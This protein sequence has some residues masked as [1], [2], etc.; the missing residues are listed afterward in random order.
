MS[1]NNGDLGS[2]LSGLIIGG[3]IG[4]AAALLLAPQS[5]EETRTI[6][7]DKSIELKEK[8]VETAEEARHR[9]EEITAE[10]RHK[11]EEL[12]EQTRARADELVKR[13]QEVY[14]EQKARIETAID[15]G[16]EAA[17]RKTD[18]VAPDELS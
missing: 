5:G 8:A 13:G 7:R 16:K 15:K 12:A 9:A 17:Q 11:A 10:A 18:E 3:L 1:D 4:A 2:F 6:I 14:E